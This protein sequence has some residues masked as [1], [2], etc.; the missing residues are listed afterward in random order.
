MIAHMLSHTQMRCR[1]MC[2]TGILLKHCSLWVKAG[3]D[4]MYFQYAI[5]ILYYV[6]SMWCLM[7]S[8]LQDWLTH[9]NCEWTLQF[10]RQKLG[11]MPCM[12]NTHTHTLQHVSL[13]FRASFHKCYKFLAAMFTTSFWYSGDSI[14]QVRSFRSVWFSTFL[15]QRSIHLILA[16]GVH[17]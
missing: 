3:H 17:V 14:G 12:H 13:M 8:V 6:G 2:Y 16:C 9:R 5:Y 10:I 1:S 15:Q 4:K 11:E 7:T